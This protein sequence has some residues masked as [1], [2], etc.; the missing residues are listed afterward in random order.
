ML[1]K[2]GF[3][4]SESVSDGHP[5]KICDQISDAILDAC[6]L[7]DPTSR[8]AIETAIKGRTLCL[9]GEITTSAQLDLRAI[10]TDVLNNIGHVDD[11]WGLDP[12][13][14][15]F[16]EDVTMQSPEIKAGVDGDDTGAGDQGLMFGFACDETPN[17]MPL[18][19]DLAHALMR[20]H[21]EHRRSLDGAAIGPDAKAQVT[22]RYA[23]GR[24]A[25]L[26]TVVLSTQHSADVPL[27]DLR[28]I[29]RRRL[30]EPALGSW[31]TSTTRIHI[32][33]AGTFVH[34]GP[35]A[36]A[37]LTGR[38]IIVDTYGGYAR[39]GGG[40]FS[41]KDATKVDR[42]GAYAARQLARDVVARGWAKACEV[43]VAYAIGLA[44]P[45]D[46]S[47]ETFGTS[48]GADPALLYRNEGIDVRDLMRPRSILTRLDL[49]RP[50]F[51]DT[52]AFGHF[53][54]SEF[55]WEWPIA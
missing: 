55:A 18:P 36:D 49:Q 3:F 4:T 41:G 17:L 43:R 35:A 34:G 24:P 44:A 47:F 39:H 16:V 31:L 6:L 32:N 9:L 26:D 54:R 22:I 15:T 5:D 52:A 19:I 48:D 14:L 12:S 10:A 45:I 20:R 28:A 37:G 11:R 30:L 13:D 2:D 50:V 38:K 51:R 25:V 27:D 1:V 53:G 42:S 33:P 7:Q 23:D 46:V 29:V 21:R 40:A 8:V